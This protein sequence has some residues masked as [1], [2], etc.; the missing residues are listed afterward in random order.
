MTSYTP[1]VETITGADL[2]GA[3]GTGRTY[4]LQNNNSIEAMMI[5]VV[6][7]AI[8][9][10][11]VWSLSSGV[12]TFSGV[13]V[14][15]DQKITI[16]YLTQSGLTISSN[17]P[18]YATPEEVFGSTSLDATVV[19]EQDVINFILAAEKQVDRMTH[20]TYWSLQDKGTAS[21]ATSTT[22]T[23]STKSW[24]TFDWEAD[25][26][27][28]Y[29]GTGAGQARE[30][31]SHTSTELTV[32]EAWSTTPDSTSKYRIVHTATEP[33]TEGLYD[34]DDT[35]VFYVPNYPLRILESMTLDSTPVTVSSVYTTLKTGRLQLSDD[36]EYGTFTSK[37][38]QRNQINY[39]WGVW[40]KPVGIPYNVKRYVIVLAALKALEAQMGGTYN[41]PSSYQL[42]EGQVTIGQAYVNIRGT[43]DVMEKEKQS[44]EK[45][46]I[47]YANIS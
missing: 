34:G 26:V 1:N 42:P 12:V 18:R 24:S 2:T 6:D 36:S 46:M 11:T 22:L 39:W 5:I 38:A 17:N 16:N 8:L 35:D 41:V 45:D 7:G 30:I 13:Y 23:D 27:W 33:Y 29:A 25:Y 43:F 3:E 9:D 21:S 4:T 14:Y 44:L 31:E 37:K 28:I 32:T 19:P 47:I 10:N 20:T 40:E 15:D